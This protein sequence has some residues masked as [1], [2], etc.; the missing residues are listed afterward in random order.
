MR[1]SVE[2]RNWL[3]D[4]NRLFDTDPSPWLPGEPVS[5]RTMDDLEAG[6]ELL[7]LDWRRARPPDYAPRLPRRDG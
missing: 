3:R 5:N 6:A 7:G 1:P 2:Y 4:G